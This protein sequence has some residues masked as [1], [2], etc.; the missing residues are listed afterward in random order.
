MV[1]IEIKVFD[2]GDYSDVL[3]IELLVV[4]GD[5]VKKD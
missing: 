2:I 5:I 4:V 1:V 3:V